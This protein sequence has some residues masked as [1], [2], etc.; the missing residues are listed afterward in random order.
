MGN[1]LSLWH[2]NKTHNRQNRLKHKLIVM[3]QYLAH[4]HITKTLRKSEKCE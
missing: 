4:Q 2:T 3:S 1:Q